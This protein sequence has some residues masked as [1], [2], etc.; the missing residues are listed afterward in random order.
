MGSSTVVN[1]FHLNSNSLLFTIADQKQ[2][3]IYSCTLENV[4]IILFAERVPF[5]VFMWWNVYE[6]E[7][8]QWWF[9]M[10]VG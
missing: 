7:L 5:S 10:K 2:A 4:L 3:M 6:Q 9:H 8:F 1:D